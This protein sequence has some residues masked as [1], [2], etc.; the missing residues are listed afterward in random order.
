M[1]AATP[2]SHPSLPPSQVPLQGSSS[3]ARAQLV[4]VPNLNS[5]RKSPAVEELP[6]L[7]VMHIQ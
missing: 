1:A 3:T 4:H 5:S 2:S 7:P 6:H